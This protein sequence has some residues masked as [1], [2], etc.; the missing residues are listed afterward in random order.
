LWRFGRLG[1]VENCEGAVD[2][3]AR[4]DDCAV[5]GATEVLD[6]V[7]SLVQIRN[8]VYD[9]LRL[10]LDELR[11]VGCELCE[12]A[13]DVLGT[14]GLRMLV[15]A[16]MEEDDLVSGAEQLTDDVGAEKPGTP[17]HQDSC[18]GSNTTSG[19]NARLRRAWR[20]IFRRVPSG[21]ASFLTRRAST[22]RIRTF[23]RS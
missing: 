23:L 10:R 1:A 14:Y 7:T 5:R 20:S 13:V 18:H 16:S 8:D 11:H 3:S 15:L 9:D 12:I 17:Q 22:L 6:A 21:P 2:V 4:D 19:R